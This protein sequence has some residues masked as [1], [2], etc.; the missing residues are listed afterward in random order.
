[1]KLSLGKEV[2]TDQIP[3]GK[4]SPDSSERVVNGAVAGR[5]AETENEELE[6]VGEGE[7]PETVPRGCTHGSHAS[8]GSERKE[9][10]DGRVESVTWK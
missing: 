6:R 3:D 10:E 7:E 5:V 4:V 9:R 2:G 1:M 8:I